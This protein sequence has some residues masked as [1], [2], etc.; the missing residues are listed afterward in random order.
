MAYAGFEGAVLNVMINLPNIKDELFKKE[1]NSKIESLKI[2]ALNQKN[3]I[4]G[5]IDEKIRK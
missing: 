2:T 5:V 4:L 1:I 3:K